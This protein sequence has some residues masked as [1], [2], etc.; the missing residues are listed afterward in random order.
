MSDKEKSPVN[1]IDQ[2]LDEVGNLSKSV[3]DKAPQGELDATIEDGEVAQVVANDMPVDADEAMDKEDSTKEDKPD[4]DIAQ[5]KSE[6]AI[7][8]DD[9]QP[10]KK[11]TWIIVGAI[12]LVLVA[13]VG[14]YAFLSRPLS[15]AQKKDLFSNGTFVEGVTIFD[16][17]VGGDTIA[18]AREKLSGKVDYSPDQELMQLRLKDQTIPVKA[19][20][21]H[22]DNTVDM[23]LNE[24]MLYGR[25]GHFI[26][27]L[28]DK[29]N[30]KK[31]GKNF[32]VTINT[33]QN[34]LDN[35][36]KLIVEKYSVQAKDADVNLATGGGEKFVYS[37]EQVGLQI[38]A[39]GLAEKIKTHIESKNTGFLDVD[40]TETLPKITLEELKKN[41]VL[42]SA[43]S[44]SVSGA[45]GRR[46]NVQK[47][48]QQINGKKVMPGENF[49]IEK[50]LGP[51]TP[52]NGWKMGGEFVNGELV[53]GY[54]G[55]ICQTSSTLFNAVIRADLEIVERSNHSQ[56]VGYVPLG[57]DAT[58]SSGGPYFIWKNN[59]KFPL[60]I[61]A[62]GGMSTL[63]I[64]I[65]G[66]PLSYGNNITY[67]EKIS[68]SGTITSG[69]RVE[70]ALVFYSDGKEVHRISWSSSYRGKPTTVA[71]TKS[72]TAAATTKTP[73]ATTKA[74]TATTKPTTAKPT[75]EKTTAASTKPVVTQ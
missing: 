66:A 3:N 20:D 52:Q 14:V 61:F 39:E 31:N 46:Q 49:N 7:D 70:S 34:S 35:L 42:R 6:I 62:S 69:R 27:R 63:T 40:Y 19:G 13:L 4:L 37:P 74:T 71:T 58:I 15:E 48:G 75:T 16:V 72:T 25:E 57:F 73:A 54:G 2:L 56:S 1:R 33:D 44:T 53:N 45:T 21:L 55:G 26:K 18:A 11:K 29:S 8:K 65:Y 22:I 23:V 28:M 68:A 5:E 60:Y 36:V 9:E 12:A 67:D 17:N 50:E 38:T 59:T 47:S 41:M 51:R 43:Y 10:N 24:A 30:A 64:E 32:D